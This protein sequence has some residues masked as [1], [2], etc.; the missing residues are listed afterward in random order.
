[1]KRHECKFCGFVFFDR[2]KRV[3]CSM[4]CRGKGVEQTE[5]KRKKLSI[6]KLAENNPQWKGDCVG[7]SVLYEWVSKYKK[8]PYLCENC[9]IERSRDLANISQKYKR[10]LDDWEWLCRRCHMKKDDRMS[11]RRKDGRFKSYKGKDG[12][13]V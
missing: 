10:D 3:Y 5:E 2:H 9:S 8:R 13:Q 1:M 12:I 4:R 6:S 11:S 7:M